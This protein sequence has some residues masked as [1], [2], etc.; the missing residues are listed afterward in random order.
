VTPHPVRVGLL[1]D[2]GDVLHLFDARLGPGPEA[3]PHARAQM[4]H[5][6]GAQSTLQPDA[7]RVDAAQQASRIVGHREP[8]CSEES[9][10]LPHT[11]YAR[12]VQL[13]AECSE[14][15]DPV[16][17]PAPR[18]ELESQP[19]GR[20][21]LHEGRRDGTEDR[22]DAARGHP[23]EYILAGPAGG[24]PRLPASS[25]AFGSLRAPVGACIAGQRGLRALRA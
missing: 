15:L 18:N 2:L 6:R 11:S 25:L 12:E 24:K 14:V 9:Q 8:R 5:H 4:E 1:H 7:R 13:R 19:E 22:A 17:Q 3:Y 16:G 10:H 20:K 23:G 21:A